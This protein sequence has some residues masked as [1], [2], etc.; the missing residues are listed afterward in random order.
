MV[1]TKFRRDES[2][3]KSPSKPSRALTTRALGLYPH[4][5][6]G[7]KVLP[8]RS[9]RSTEG[10]G[11]ADEEGD[12]LPLVEVSETG[13]SLFGDLSEVASSALNLSFK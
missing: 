6:F 5:L 1:Q 7:R 11:I 2:R 4:S 3:S 13:S 9:L 10:I 8:K 12:E